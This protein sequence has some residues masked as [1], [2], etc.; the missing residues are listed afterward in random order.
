MG[1]TTTR[2]KYKIKPA[3]NLIEKVAIL[4]S[5]CAGFMDDQNSAARLNDQ[6]CDT[7]YAIDVDVIDLYLQPDSNA[8]RYADV[9]EEGPDSFTSKM[10]AFLLGD[11]LIKS[12]VPLLPGH[13]RLKCRFLI[14]PPHD[15]ELLRLLSA[16]HRELSQVPDAIDEATFEELS[17]I[18]MIYERDGNEQALLEAL[19]DHVPDLVELFNPYRGPKAAL[20]RYARMPETTFQRIETYI[21]TCPDKTFTFPILDPVNNRKDRET[22]NLL[23][24]KWEVLLK[25]YWRKKR[26]RHSKSAHNIRVDAEVLATIEHLNSALRGQ[27]KQ[28]ILV[29][30]SNDLFK[31]A[32]TYKPYA[33]DT[34]SFADMYLRHPQAFLAHPRFFAL[35]DTQHA[36]FKII[37]WLNLLFPDEILPGILEPGIVRPGFQRRILGGRGQSISRGTEILSRYDKDTS[38][39][40]MEWQT[41]VAAVAKAR[42]ADGLKFDKKQ[43][44][45]KLANKLKDLRESKK[46]S[47]EKL[48]Q[49]ASIESL[50]SISCLYSR[51]VWV[52]L[53]SKAARLQFK[54]VP[55]LR[56]DDVFQELEK[57]CDLV[58]QLQ[59]RS[60][61][62]RISEEELDELLELN[63]KVEE[64]DKSLY[65]AHVIHALAFAVKGHWHATITLAKIAMAISDNLPETER[66][67]RLGREAAYLACIATRRSARNRSGL[68]NANEHLKEAIRREN[69]GWANDIRF[70]SESLA[71]KTRYIYFDLFCE[72]RQIDKDIFSDTVHKLNDLIYEAEH[73][74]N[75][76]V[77]VWVQRQNLT[78]YF[79]LLLI[80]RY[81]SLKDKI[82]VGDD[83]IIPLAIF[84]SVLRDIFTHKHK[85]EDDPYATLICNISTAIWDPNDEKRKCA[86]DAAS[87]ALSGEQKAF[88]PYDKERFT[89]LEQSISELP[90]QT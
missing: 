56:F 65:H 45:L 76:R 5:K 38:H 54:G 7:Y 70:S 79:T 83:I 85:L 78:N 58:V 14:A 55:A 11:F 60:S 17:N 64:A 16:I 44:A 37:D 13:E 2:E 62:R 90:N 48:R 33:R 12:S 75:M 26:K 80:A 50:E 6:H 22:A 82:P 77:K 88:M 73:E 39:L 42:Y 25:R 35:S 41:H 68:D 27:N 3:Y 52:G 67:F 47:I 31:V 28:I 57:Y 84:Q 72:S 69:P 63:K 86:R 8:S 10:L 32:E 74:Q 23:I 19:S 24:G 66:G 49:M 51:T 29:T 59:L 61:V 36:A 18:F 21:E 46:W 89:L 87:K 53:W 4:L 40:L 34:R 9:L 30:G 71:I 20:T 43:V 15:E 81:H 1:I